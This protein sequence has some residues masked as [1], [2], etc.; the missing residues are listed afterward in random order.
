MNP[1]SEPDPLPPRIHPGR[2]SALTLQLI[3][4]VLS[5]PSPHQA[6]QTLEELRDQL[7][8]RWQED[9][10]LEEA[11]RI[12]LMLAELD[13]VRADLRQVIDRRHPAEEPFADSPED[14]PSPPDPPPG[15]EILRRR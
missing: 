12:D 11:S 8:G 15:D 6:L 5:A 13:E 2:A 7:Q 3:D 10:S 14:E 4:L 9:L 1:P